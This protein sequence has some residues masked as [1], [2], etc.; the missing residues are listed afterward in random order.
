M[1]RSR[2]CGVDFLCVIPLKTQYTFCFFVL[3]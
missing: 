2:I 1:F 3:K